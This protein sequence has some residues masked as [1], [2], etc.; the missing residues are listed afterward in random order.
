MFLDYQSDVLD[1]YLVPQKLGEGI[2][3]WGYQ[4]FLPDQSIKADENVARCYACHQRSRRHR[5]FMFTFSDALRFG[6]DS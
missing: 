6:D 4:Y 2:D 5:Q 1:R 3:D